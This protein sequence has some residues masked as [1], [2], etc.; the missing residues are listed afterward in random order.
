MGTPR[1]G[2]K[3]ASLKQ[4]QHLSPL[5]VAGTARR[6]SLATPEMPVAFYLK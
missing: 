4:H 6:Q 2:R 5:N 1:V 3:R